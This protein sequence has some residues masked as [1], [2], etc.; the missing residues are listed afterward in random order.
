MFDEAMQE[1][2]SAIKLLKK[3]FNT[4][5]DKV[6]DINTFT[7][8]FH[9][10]TDKLE[11]L[12]L[13]DIEKRK[14]YYQDHK[15]VNKALFRDNEKFTVDYK[16]LHKIF[17]ELEAEESPSMLMLLLKVPNLLMISVILICIFVWT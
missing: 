9:L 7:R 8:N 13:K 6:K 10:T 3:K 15:V 1:F 17:D 4:I 11:K 5:D 16:D 12:Y 14:E 2:S